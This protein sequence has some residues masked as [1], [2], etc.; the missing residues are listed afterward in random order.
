MSILT[1]N[2]SRARA[3]PLA[4]VPLESKFGK[5]NDAPPRVKPADD[6]DEVHSSDE[7]EENTNVHLSEEEEE[8]DDTETPQDK[9]LKLAKLYLQEIENEE[10]ARAEDRELLENNVSQRLANEYL[11]SVGRLRR[12]VADTYAGYDAQNVRRVKHKL[13]ELPVTCVCLTSDNQFLFTG[14]KS[15]I[16]IKWAA[17]TMHLVGHFDCNK[18]KSQDEVDRS[19]KKRRPQ[20]YALAVTT[21]SKFVV[22]RGGFSGSFEP[23][24]IP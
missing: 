21:D 16:V 1:W 14:N 4:K 3:C 5:K 23:S 13:H 7:D 20:T 24:T 17:D 9:R 2:M 19:K 18:G 22:S 6:D 15:A 10:K 12:R 11:D 8:A